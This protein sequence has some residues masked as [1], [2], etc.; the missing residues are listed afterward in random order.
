MSID[1]PNMPSIFNRILPNLRN[2]QIKTIIDRTQTKTELFQVGPATV[3]VP[4]S[5]NITL[6]QY[7]DKVS[8]S[9]DLCVQQS[10]KYSR[11]NA[12]IRMLVIISTCVSLLPESNISFDVLVSFCSAS[13]FLSFLEIFFK[14]YKLY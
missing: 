8:K 11:L 12:L 10:K 5:L 14:L 9:R 13:V 7:L 1:L 4:V 3:N 2:E 6:D